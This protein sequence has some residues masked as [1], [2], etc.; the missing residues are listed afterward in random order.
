MDF[1]VSLSESQL[2]SANEDEEGEGQ[3]NHDF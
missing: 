2:W 1:Q 3:G